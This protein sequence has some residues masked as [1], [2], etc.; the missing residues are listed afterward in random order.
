VSCPTSSFLPQHPDLTWLASTRSVGRVLY[1]SLRRI[2]HARRLILADEELGWRYRDLVGRGWRFFACPDTDSFS[3]RC[4]I[5]EVHPRLYKHCR[6]RAFQ[7]QPCCGFGSLPWGEGSTKKGIIDQAR[8]ASPSI[9]G[10]FTHRE[11]GSQL[12]E[13]I[14]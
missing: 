6:L 1:P 4:Q 8:A 14:T 3:G 12:G 9:W 2:R 11:L 7:Y 13:A 5:R 10:G